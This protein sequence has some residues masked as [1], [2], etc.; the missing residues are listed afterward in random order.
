VLVAAAPPAA[1]P[2][3]APVP[4]SQPALS[5]ST[6]AAHGANAATEGGAVHGQV[7]VPAAATL[8]EQDTEPAA[9]VVRMVG[10]GV[11]FAAFA[12]LEVRRR[13]RR[14]FAKAK[15]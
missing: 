5:A 11:L 8:P 4:V 2:A 14:S 9:G 15:R 7:S 6:S 10:A 13:S 1:A 3:P 12:A